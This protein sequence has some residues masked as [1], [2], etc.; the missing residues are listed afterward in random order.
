M[1]HE[2]DVMPILNDL[3]FESL[4]KLNQHGI[5]FWSARDQGNCTINFLTTAFHGHFG[6]RFEMLSFFRTTH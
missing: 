5:E 1:D 6:Q 3:S 2:N 4:K